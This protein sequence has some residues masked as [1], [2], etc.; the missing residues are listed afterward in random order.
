LPGTTASCSL[1]SATLLTDAVGVCAAAGS[2]S[3]QARARTSHLTIVNR[4]K[5]ESP[6]E[7]V[8]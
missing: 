1:T 2:V 4:F 6:N 5:D 7:V 3:K 8:S